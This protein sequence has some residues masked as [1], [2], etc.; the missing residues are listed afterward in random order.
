LKYARGKN[1][2][3]RKPSKEKEMIMLGRAIAD[4]DIR[5]NRKLS[6]I[7]SPAGIKVAQ[8]KITT[9][10]MPDEVLKG[11][12]QRMDEELALIEERCLPKQKK[13]YSSKKR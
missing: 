4:S 13:N 1:M 11:Y 3:I 8:D 6:E 7:V 12:H 2:E 5:F 10:A 9:P